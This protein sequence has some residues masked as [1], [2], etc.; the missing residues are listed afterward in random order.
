LY[1][2]WTQTI[3]VMACASASFCEKADGRSP[4]KEQNAEF[5]GV[6]AV[7][8]LPLWVECDTFFRE[9]NWRFLRGIVC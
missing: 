7:A 6:C 9:E 5:I 3:S 2:F 1:K 8:G 4:V